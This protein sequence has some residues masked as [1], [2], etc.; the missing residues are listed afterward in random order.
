LKLQNKKFILMYGD[1]SLSLYCERSTPSP[2]GRV[3]CAYAWVR[4]TRNT[5]I[6]NVIEIAK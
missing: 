1:L 6:V 3:A 4:S 5:K 2:K